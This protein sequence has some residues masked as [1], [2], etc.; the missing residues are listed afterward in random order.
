MPELQDAALKVMGVLDQ[1]QELDLL[2]IASIAELPVSSAATALGELAR[3]DLVAIRDDKYSLNNTALG[4]LL[5]K[6]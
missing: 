5:Q 4:Q 3:Y 2:Q 6:I 1:H